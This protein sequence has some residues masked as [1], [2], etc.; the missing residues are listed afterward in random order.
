M[1]QCNICFVFVAGGY[2]GYTDKRMPGFTGCLKR[3]RVNRKRLDMFR[4]GSN[5]NL[6]T[7]ST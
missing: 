4:Q 7:C 6:Q 3:I 1:P 5:T 2:L